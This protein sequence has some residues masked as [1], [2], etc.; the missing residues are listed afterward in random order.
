MRI[1]PELKSVI[2]Q[3]KQNGLYVNNEIHCFI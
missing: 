3:I 1:Y 2:Q